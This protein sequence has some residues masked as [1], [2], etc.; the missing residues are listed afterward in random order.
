MIQRG[1]RVP[2]A[3]ETL[4]RFAT[5]GARELLAELLSHPALA[6]H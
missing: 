4:V 5:A 3:M 2:E 6:C 1:E